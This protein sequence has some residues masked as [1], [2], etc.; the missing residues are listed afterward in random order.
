MKKIARL[1]GLPKEIVL[2]KDSKFTLKFW[3]GMF[4]RFGTNLNFSTTYHP[5]LDGKTRVRKTVSSWSFHKMDFL[6]INLCVLMDV[7][8]FFSFTEYFS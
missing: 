1:H 6:R 2:Y 7:R 3:R 5:Q 8:L 4:K